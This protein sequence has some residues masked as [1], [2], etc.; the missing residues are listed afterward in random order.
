MH[1]LSPLS[2]LSWQW[3]TASFNIP[4]L[5]ILKS[6]GTNKAGQNVA[7][8]L[9]PNHTPYTAALLTFGMTRHNFLETDSFSLNIDNSR[10]YNYD[11][12]FRKTATT[13]Y[14][15]VIKIVTTI[16]RGSWV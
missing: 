2:S 15:N 14:K 9:R 16:L 5:S 11:G 3:I 1:K 7:A 8:K 13:N 10:K 12:L 4:V 6:G